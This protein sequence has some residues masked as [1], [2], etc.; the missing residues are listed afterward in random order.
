MENWKTNMEVTAIKEEE[1]IKMYK[2]SDIEWLERQDYASNMSI[3][4]S[5]IS[6]KSVSRNGRAPNGIGEDD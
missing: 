4:I 1:Y 3:K 6:H 5:E 2:D